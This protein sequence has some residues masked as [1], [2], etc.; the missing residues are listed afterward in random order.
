[1]AL[2]VKMHLMSNPILRPANFPAD[3]EP[4]V[5]VLTA[6]RPH[7]P[8]SLGE[9]QHDLYNLEPDLRPTF[10]VAELA[11]QI[12]GLT[13]W[14]RN[15]GAYHPQRCSLELCVHPDVEGRGIGRLLW[16]AVEQDLSQLAMLSVT[17]QV[18][19]DRPR[20]LRF[21]AN[22]DFFEIKRDFEI[23]RAHV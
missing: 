17:V 12:V 21:A 2:G 14:Q 13:E 22:N 3:L 7:H 1:M 5:A 20:A 23:G 15:A 10:I 6:A 16:N 18:D 4:I 11:G 8:R 9:L 19:E